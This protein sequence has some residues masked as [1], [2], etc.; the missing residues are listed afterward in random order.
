[1][2]SDGEVLV[3]GRYQDG[4][5]LGVFLHSEDAGPLSDRRDEFG[6]IVVIVNVEDE[7]H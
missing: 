1:M 7:R 5:P 3:A 2:P 6:G 4:I